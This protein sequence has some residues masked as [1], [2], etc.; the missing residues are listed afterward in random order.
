MKFLLLFYPFS[1][2]HMMAHPLRTLVVIFGIAMGASV[3]TSVRMSVDAATNGFTD[4]MDRVTG[5]AV[6]H[7][8]RPDGRVPG[9]L[10]ATLFRM[11]EVAAVSPVLST[12]MVPEKGTAPFLVMGLAPF[13]DLP[14]RVWEPAGEGGEMAEL[15]SR[16][17]TIV[18]PKSYAVENGISVG[19]TIAFRHDTSWH[20]FEIV[21]L[22]SRTGLPG[23]EGGRVAVCDIATFQEATGTH[24][25]VDRIDLIPKGEKGA[26]ERAIQ[27]ALSSDLTLVPAS[28]TRRSGLAMIRAY[29]MNLTVLSFVS[30]FVGM[31]LVYSVVALNAASRTRE[32]AT[33]RALGAGKKTVFFLFLGEG[34]GIG[35]CGWLVSLPLSRFGYHFLKDGI[36]ET[37]DILFVRTPVSGKG[38]GMGELVAGGGL[39]VVVAAMAALVPA[40]TASRIPPLLLMGKGAAVDYGRGGGRTMAG[41][42]GLAF[43]LVPVAALFPAVSGIPAGGYLATFFLFFGTALVI[44]MLMDRLG[45]PASRILGRRF[46]ITGLIAGRNLAATGARTAVS[47]GALITAVALFVALSVMVTSF[48]ETVRIWVLQSISGDLFIRPKMADLNGYQT[49]LPDPVVEDILGEKGWDAVLYRRIHIREGNRIYHLEAMDLA[50]FY[51][52]GSFLVKYG[53]PGGS[54]AAGEALPLLAS[55]VAANRYGVRIGDTLSFFV[56][57]K[58][59]PFYVT[60]IIRDYRTRGVA[61]FCDRTALAKRTGNNAVSGIR[62][63]GQKGMAEEETETFRTWLMTRYGD[64]LDVASGV[65]LRGAVLAIFD[66]TFGITFVL[67]A[68]AL[69]IA[70][71]GIATTMNIRVLERL[72]QLHTLVAVGAS[73]SQIRAMIRWEAFLIVM[74]SVVTGAFC[75]AGLSILLTDVINRQSFGWTFLRHVDVPALGT[76]LFIVVITG[77]AAAEPAIR[78]VL[79]QSSARILREG[80]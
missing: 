25:M 5:K 22:L 21:G 24:G 67:L 43:F 41:M 78:M 66:A 1:I 48:R 30:L 23:A 52:H 51:S 77:I 68:V 16:P 54:R 59:I 58:E 8:I 12:Y 74:I 40:V 57:G 69:A 39:T 4:S 28:E 50:T 36:R 56:D 53:A 64:A 9:S 3:F 44:P 29:R 34:I 35:F 55:E 11:P 76:G 70:A 15:I 33:L 62:L 63:F 19:D 61:L 7:V 71:L 27:A 47:A 10:V 13:L 73:P 79:G 32:L 72:T 6:Y 60:A 18:V 46:G 31:F 26:A 65:A 42:G 45:H 17:Q 75:G 20:H 80:L 14:F 38:F 37:I 49:T 2:R